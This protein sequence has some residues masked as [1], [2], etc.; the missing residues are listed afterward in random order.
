MC[1]GVWIFKIFFES[2][3]IFF[4][5]KY[6]AILFSEGQKLKA[7]IYNVSFFVIGHNE[8]FIPKA[9]SSQRFH[10]YKWF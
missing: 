7:L 5:K 6:F 8:Q 10:A 3:F 9:L 1:N 4:L 2:F